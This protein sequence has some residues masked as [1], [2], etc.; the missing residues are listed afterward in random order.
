[1]GKTKFCQGISDISDSYAGFILDQWGVLHN[2]EKAYEGVAECLRELKARNKFIIILSNSG[3]RA[4]VNKES[5]K[6][7]GIGPSLYDVIVTSGEL[8][9]QGLKD[10]DEGV[11][12]KLGTKCFLMSRGSDR[13]IVDGLG[14]EIVKDVN[15]AEFLLISGSDAPEKNMVDYYEPILKAAV[16][17]RLKALCAN[18]DS[19]ALMGTG[20]VMGPG[21]IARRYEDF[22]GVVHYIGKPHKPIFQH[23]IKLLQE[24]N[25]YPGETVMVGDTMAHDIIG[26]ASVEMDT[27]LVKNGLHYGAF[28]SCHTPGDVDKALNTLTLQYNNVR[29]TYLV[30]RLKWGRALPDRKH[31][32]RKLA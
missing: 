26:A 4:D 25:I 14:L 19:Q 32:K 12:Q 27:C 21:L 6:K 24:K 31:K 22:G 20:Y 7:M 5:L 29:P 8:T 1:M 10:Q 17:R 28:K 2:G 16:R 18:P 13:S 23:C 3:K 30:D 11:F 9:W 15:D